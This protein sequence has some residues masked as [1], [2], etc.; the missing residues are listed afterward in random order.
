[1]QMKI[2]A[3]S[4]ARAITIDYLIYRLSVFGSADGATA[5]PFVNLSPKRVEMHSQGN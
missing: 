4:S 1:M 3:S 5:R 2:G